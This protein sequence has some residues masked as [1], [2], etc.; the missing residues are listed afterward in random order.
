MH[1][2]TW[3]R[4]ILRDFWSYKLRSMLV[5]ASVVIGVLGI[6]SLTTLGQI[7]TDQLHAD[8]K[9]DELAMLRIYLR[10]PEGAG[11]DPQDLAPLLDV[12]GVEDVEAQAA[13]RFAW[14]APGD[15]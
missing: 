13:Y 4:K 8:I 6:I 11:G 12:E 5:S 2:H 3:V 7:L 14:K 9:K 15:S 10:L 1:L